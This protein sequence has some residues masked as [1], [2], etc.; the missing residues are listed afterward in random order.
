MSIR[1]PKPQN[2]RAARR[3]KDAWLR[4]G[5]WVLVAIFVLSSVGVVFGVFIK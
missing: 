4:A 1:R 3:R 5:V 2:T